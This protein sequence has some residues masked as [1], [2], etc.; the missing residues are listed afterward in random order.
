MNKSY[1]PNYECD[2]H[3]HT[4]RSDGNDTPRE[5]ILKAAALKM[6]AVAITDHDITP[7]LFVNDA[8]G[9]SMSSVDFAKK[10]GVELVLGYEFSCDTD[11]DDVHIIGYRCDWEN[12]E[13][14]NESVQAKKSKADAYKR[15]CEV[16]SSNGYKIDF[17]RD[18]LHY[19][20]E[21]GQNNKREP[22]EVEK[23]LI[24]E[25]MA[26]KG[27]APTWQAAKLMVKDSPVFNIKRKKINPYRAIK[28]IK[29]AS[30]IA[31]LAHPYLIDETVLSEI[32]GK[33]TR[34]GYINKLIEAGL[35]GI[36]AV[37]TYDKT[38]YKGKMTPREIQREIEDVF[39]GKVRFFT[40]G[41]DYH[42][43]GKK[44]VKNPRMIGEA[45]IS[46]KE[47]IKIFY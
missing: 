13:I 40:G 42:N 26:K 6:K 34:R 20:D 21:S 23:K 5:F 43:D 38:S 15:L 7:P 10:H 31:V 2:L 11:V 8:D 44:G 22:E 45:G 30:G 36:E 4:N 17:D 46:Y 28:I 33:I 12:K 37:Y 47:F 1:I 27:F 25:T 9:S 19:T 3:C 39:G 18:I 32:T 29:D 41:S 16:L 14:V 35:D 24:F